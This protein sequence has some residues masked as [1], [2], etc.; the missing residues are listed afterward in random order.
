MTR[1]RH[2]QP[3]HIAHGFD[4]LERL[5]S[6]SSFI[7]SMP[8]QPGSMVTVPVSNVMPLPTSADTRTARYDVAGSCR[9]TISRGGSRRRRA[10]PRHAHAQR[11]DLLLVEDI[12]RRAAVERDAR[13]ALRELAGVSASAG[14][15]P[16]SPSCKIARFSL[17]VPRG[18]AAPSRARR[19]FREVSLT[20]GNY[21]RQRV[22]AS[23]GA[24]GDVDVARPPRRRRPSHSLA[25]TREPRSPD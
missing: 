16:A 6:M 22:P 1:D 13:G 11:R 8:S 15:L 18:E 17:R 24:R 5:W 9:N 14:P 10:R 21:D 19:T 23:A 4:V 25:R 7:F 12:D 3:L 20:V 2:V